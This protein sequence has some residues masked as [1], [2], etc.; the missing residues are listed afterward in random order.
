MTQLTP[1][2]EMKLELGLIKA[3]R[4]VLRTTFNG[5]IVEQDALLVRIDEN[6]ARDA[7]LQQKA[8][9]ILTALNS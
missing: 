9:D 2:E 4:K 3:E 5:L 7:E 8:L 6:R 1:S